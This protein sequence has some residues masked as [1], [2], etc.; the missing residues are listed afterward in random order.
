MIESVFE[1]AASGVRLL[2][3]LLFIIRLLSSHKYSNKKVLKTN[4]IR[5][6]ISLFIV[7]SVFVLPIKKAFIFLSIGR[8]MRFMVRSE[9]VWIVEFVFSFRF[10]TI[11]IFIFNVFPHFTR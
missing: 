9:I 1:K 5:N 4:K 8:L 2:L 6:P 11:S 10:S 7:P 3:L